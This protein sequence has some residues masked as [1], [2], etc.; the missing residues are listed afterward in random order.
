ML[1]ER[2]LDPVAATAGEAEACLVEVA[3][4]ADGGTR[5]GAVE[6]SDLLP[7]LPTAAACAPATNCPASLDLQQEADPANSGGE[8]DDGV[9]RARWGSKGGAP[10]TR[11]PVEAVM[12]DA[13][14][15]LM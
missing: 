15:L 3:G 6:M 11:A 9:G 12:T 5:E 4:W 8:N 10:A 14:R 13:A 1:W 7:S 2:N